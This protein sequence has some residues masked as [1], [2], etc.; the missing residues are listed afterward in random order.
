MCFEVYF[1]VR[2]WGVNLLIKLQ[3]WGLHRCLP[4]NFAKFSRTHFFIEHL[5]WL[6]LII[7]RPSKK[8]HLFYGTTA[9]G[10]FWS[11]LLLLLATL[12]FVFDSNSK[13]L[14][15]ASHFHWSHFHQ[16]YF[17]FQLFPCFFC[18]QGRMQLFKEVSQKFQKG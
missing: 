7:W 3:A 6:L 8:E 11:S 1:C 2:L 14:N 13:N 18:L 15:L 10:C 5:R 17:L 12:M 9:S 4:V 16:C